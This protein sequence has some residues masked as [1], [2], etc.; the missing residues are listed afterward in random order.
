MSKWL[1]FGILAAL[2]LLLF[3][4]VQGDSNNEVLPPILI[5]SVVG[6]LAWLSGIGARSRWRRLGRVLCFALLACFAVFLFG[7]Q[8]DDKSVLAAGAL[9]TYGLFLICIT[10]LAWRFFRGEFRKIT[11]TLDDSAPD[12]VRKRIAEIG[13]NFKAFQEIL[14]REEQGI[15]AAMKQMQ[16]SL[17]A[18]AREFSTVEKE[19][20]RSREE[21]KQYRELANLTKEQQAL[22][23][24]LIQRDKVKDYV[25]GFVLGLL[26]SLMATG[27]WHLLSTGFL[28]TATGP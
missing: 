20:E 5:F 10:V 6:V 26:A 19:L 3:L 25:I 14:R 18:Q 2:D 21:A 4:M 16:E 13:N 12:A 9:P 23:L 28:R 22:F 27:A 1:Y 7:I 17:D 8:M 15:A 24:T 11:T